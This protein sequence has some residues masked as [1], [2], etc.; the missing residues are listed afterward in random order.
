MKIKVLLFAQLRE[1]FETGDRVMTV[2]EGVTI[3]EVGTQILKEAKLE[4]PF[5]YAVNESYVKKDH[6]LS[7]GDEVAFITPIAGG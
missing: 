2:E 4:I 5:L 3:G 7:E 1:T 6:E